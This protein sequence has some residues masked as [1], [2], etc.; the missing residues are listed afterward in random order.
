MPSYAYITM[1]FIATNVSKP[2]VPPCVG[3]AGWALG[4][5]VGSAL[6]SVCV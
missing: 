5:M 4:G 6:F 2:P 1:M 3:F